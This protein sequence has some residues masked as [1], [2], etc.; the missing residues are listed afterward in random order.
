MLSY[1]G[2]EL[3]ALVVTRASGLAAQAGLS[4]ASR[5][6]Y[7]MGKPLIILPTL[8]DAL[9]LLKPDKTLIYLP[10]EPDNYLNSFTISN[11]DRVMLVFSGQDDGPSRS[12]VALGQPFN[13]KGFIN[14]LPPPAALSL[15]LRELEELINQ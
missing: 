3:K 7:R 8:K 13:F 10:G 5:M 4:E 6:L 15:T 12:E 14:Y 1:T 2:Q 11:S 9:E